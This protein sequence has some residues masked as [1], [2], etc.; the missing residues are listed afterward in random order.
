MQVS[1]FSVI[2]SNKITTVFIRVLRTKLYTKN[3]NAKFGA[4]Y[5]QG[6]R[7]YA[8]TPEGTWVQVRIINESYARERASRVYFV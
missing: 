8:V 3:T 1:T 5:K 7:F 4:P 2:T 6:L